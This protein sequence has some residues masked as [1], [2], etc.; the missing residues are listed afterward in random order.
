MG[1]F[2]LVGFG[3]LK[4]TRLT[5]RDN[6][7]MLAFSTLFTIN[8]ATSNVSLAVVSVPLHQVLRSTCPVAAIMI[9][10]LMGRTYSTATYI[11]IIPLILGVALAT[12]GDY[13]CTTYGLFLT[14]LGVFLAAVKT[15]ATN[16]IMTGSLALSA[17]EVLL[18]MSPLATIQCVVCA[19]FTG[20]VEAAHLA[21]TKGELSG[22]FG[23]A[24]L[25][26]GMIAFFL[27]IVSLKAN[28]MAGALTMTVAGNMKQTLTI[29]IGIMLFKVQTG[30]VNAVGIVMTVAG[31][32]LYSKVELDTKRAR[33][34][35]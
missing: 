29:L 15:V 3:S 1:C 12:I 30:M 10:R 7:I 5:T 21:Y 34:G 9:Y 24:L 28:K 27:N 31:A 17:L 2:A 33:L 20:E 25:A 32:A 8:I 14:L 22:H 4:A 13:Y 23:L 16:K 18:R 19:F 35:A 26:N 6:L 11:S